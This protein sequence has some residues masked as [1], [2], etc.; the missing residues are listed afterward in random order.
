MLVLSHN[1]QLYALIVISF[2]ACL[3]F[4]NWMRY[5]PDGNLVGNSLSIFLGLLFVVLFAFDKRQSFFSV[6]PSLVIF[7]SLFLSGFLLFF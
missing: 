3:P 6:T 1:R 5:A 2:I 7:L 4:L